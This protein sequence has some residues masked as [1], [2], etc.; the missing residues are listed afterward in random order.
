MYKYLKMSD[1]F[2]GLEQIEKVKKPR[3]KKEMTAERKAQLKEQL[4]KGRQ[5]ALENRKKKALVKK[6]KKD[7][8]NT[9]IEEYIEKAHKKKKN[10]NNDNGDLTNQI[11]ML[12]ERLSLYENKKPVEK[13]EPLINSFKETIKTPLKTIQEVKEPINKKIGFIDKSLITKKDTETEKNFNTF[14]SSLWG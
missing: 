7:E 4:K 13:K 3:K 8:A 2:E 10:T 9:E 1:M 12:T 11:K 14:S 5:T 6:I